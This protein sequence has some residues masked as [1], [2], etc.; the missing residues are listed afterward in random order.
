[1][2]HAL[3]PIFGCSIG[4]GF[5]QDVGSVARFY[6]ANMDVL[7]GATPAMK[8]GRESRPGVWL[9]VHDVCRSV[10]LVPPVLLGKQVRL[11]SGCV[12]GPDV[13]LGDGCTVGRKTTIAR[14]V[15]LESCAVGQ[16]VVIDSCLLGSHSCIGDAVHVPTGS[17]LGDYSLVHTNAIWTKPLS[18]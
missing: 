13:I 14:S 5:R 8:P 18:A 10:R 7:H 17:A 15:L 3:A 16:G 11:G 1:V 4:N 2:K 6:K 9:Q 12:I